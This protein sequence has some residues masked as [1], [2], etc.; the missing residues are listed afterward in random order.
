VVTRR[1]PRLPL[2]EQNSQ[3]YPQPSTEK[4]VEASTPKNKEEE[5]LPY[6][7]DEPEDAVIHIKPRAMGLLPPTLDHR[8]HATVRQPNFRGAREEIWLCTFSE[9]SLHFP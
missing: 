7:Y 9:C 3:S 4:E 1:Y 6:D 8:Y 5:D 2:P